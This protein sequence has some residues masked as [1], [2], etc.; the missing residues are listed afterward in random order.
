M[1]GRCIG[2]GAI[3][4]GVTSELKGNAQVQWSETLSAD[5]PNYPLGVRNGYVKVR[6]DGL[7]IS[8]TFIGETGAVSWSRP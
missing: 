5:D 2:H 4:Y 1:Y 6:L 8:E 7:Q 3:P